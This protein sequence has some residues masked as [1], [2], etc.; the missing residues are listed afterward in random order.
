MFKPIV[1]GMLVLASAASQAQNTANVGDHVSLRATHHL[2]VPVHNQP[3]GNHDLRR[4]PMAQT[5]ARRQ[6][7]VDGPG[8][9]RTGQGWVN[10]KYLA[11][12]IA[13]PIPTTDEQEVQVWTS[14]EG[15]EQALGHKGRMLK[16]ADAPMAQ[17]IL[18]APVALPYIV[19]ILDPHSSRYS[20]IARA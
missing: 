16:P 17:S 6:R 11:G 9:G 3:Q 8:D 4:V 12:V 5:G 1:A 15:C 18:A 10:T 19:T 2:G 14:P 20:G 13:S 7:P